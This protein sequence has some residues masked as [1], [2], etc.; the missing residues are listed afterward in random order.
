MRRHLHTIIGA[1]VFG[2]VMMGLSAESEAARPNIVLIMVDD[3]GFSDIGCYGSEISTPNLD[4]LASGGLRFRQ[5]YNT[6]RCCPT[7]AALMTGLYQHQAG[8]GHMTG[9]FGR[10]AYQGHLNDQ[11]VTIAEAM[12]PAGYY[13]AISGK[14]HVGSAPEH[15]PL[16][17]GFD[18][19]Y[20]IPE[21]GGHH[22]RL[23]PG[24]HLVIDDT[25]IDVPEGWYS[26]TA[27]TDYALRFIDEGAKADKPIFLYVAYTAPH[28]P[29]QAPAEE[30]AKYRGK[31]KAGWQAMREARFERQQQM[32]LFDD[33]VKLSPIDPKTPDWSKLKDVDE[34]DLRL[35][36][37]AAMVHLVD[38]G[39]GR[40]VDKLKQ[41]GLY[42]DTLILFLSDNGA[43]AEGGPTGFI[44]AKRGDP[45]A[46]TGTPTSYVS[47]GIAGANAC[48]APFRRYKMYNHE[49]GI[50]TPLVAHW[51]NGIT[52][53]LRGKF[54]P[55][56]GHVIDLLPTFVDL[57]G[58]DYPSKSGDRTI[59]PT[60]GRSLAPVFAGGSIDRPEGLFWEH[61]GNAAVRI[62][63][64]KLVREHGRPWE[65]YNLAKDR[66]ELDDLSKKMPDKA[67]ALKATW[68]AWADR[69]GVE[70][71]PVKK[72]KGK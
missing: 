52:P 53:T 56:V 62:G 71:W 47:F 25:A 33:N 26:T 9:D 69:V 24:R 14:W 54:T 1:L 41:R 60:P 58:I 8:M 10:P 65:L 18:R 43:S 64:W 68:K 6:G 31:Y 23:L 27:F 55:A 72:R 12:K 66:T 38:E 7:R 42:D 5:F 13:T 36:T 34:M 48:D 29:L 57:A 70:P 40:I 46:K 2:F 3:M 22:Y 15:W 37:H 51:P 32:G 49:G 61:Q 63:D 30:I 59:T 16:K 20:G 44:N 28:W 45:K 17:R 4:R 50:A 11:C 35:A 39:V 19:F 21:G 67:T